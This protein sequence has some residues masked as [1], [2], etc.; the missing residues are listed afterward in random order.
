M[1]QFTSFTV[2]DR[3]TTPVA[4]TF[5]PRKPGNSLVE[6]REPGV[7]PI[8]DRKYTV[9]WRESNGRIRV[10]CV[11]ADPKVVTETIN[12]VDVT[13]VPH[14]NFA[15]V[16]FTFSEEST[17]QERQNLVGMFANSLA[18]SVTVIDDTVTGLEAIW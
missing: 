10:R 2:N 15:D 18:A 9:S 8:A 4:H 7:V 12:G 14:V 13:K 11:L 3:E 17:L 16:T 5:E 1:S 6:F